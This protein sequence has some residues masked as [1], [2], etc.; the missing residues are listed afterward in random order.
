[1][2]GERGLRNWLHLASP[3]PGRFYKKGHSHVRLVALNQA[4]AAAKSS[5]FLFKGLLRYHWSR[6]Y[7]IRCV[8][9]VEVEVNNSKVM[10][11]VEGDK[12][13]IQGWMLLNE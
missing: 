1:M 3:T 12:D 2:I 8:L 7:C 9:K 6:I 13:G 11:F 10:H 4:P 5:S